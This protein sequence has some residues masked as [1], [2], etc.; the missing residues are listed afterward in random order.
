[1]SSHLRRQRRM[2]AA[3]QPMSQAS[4][5]ELERE[6]RRAV[7]RDL[8]LGVHRCPLRAKGLRGLFLR[9]VQRRGSPY[10]VRAVAQLAQLGDLLATAL[11]CVMCHLDG[12]VFMLLALVLPFPLALAAS[13]LVGI[14]VVFAG[15]ATSLRAQAA[16]NLLSFLCAC[17]MLAGGTAAFFLADTPLPTAVFAPGVVALVKLALAYLLSLLIAH[18]ESLTDREIAAAADAMDDGPGWSRHSAAAVAP[19]NALR[20]SDEAG[21]EAGAEAEPSWAADEGSNNG[22]MAQSRPAGWANPAAAA[23]GPAP[24][25]D[26]APALGPGP[27]FGARFDTRLASRS[28]ARSLSPESESMASMPGAEAA[29][30]DSPPPHMAAEGRGCGVGGYGGYADAVH[31]AGASLMM[32]GV[33]SGFTS[34]VDE[35]ELL[36]ELGGEDGG[37]EGWQ[38][39]ESLLPGARDGGG[40]A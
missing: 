36:H 18:T 40:R 20:Q 29:A 7:R 38:G 39:E 12:A 9:N 16:L 6:R 30:A 31:G 27:A 37:V 28:S 24:A 4:L 35:H 15:S 25:R 1:M 32:E 13:P 8:C 22:A 26:H 11:A 19:F 14:P 34:T 10:G 2:Q 5:E 3:W 23:P 21:T 33:D 17:A